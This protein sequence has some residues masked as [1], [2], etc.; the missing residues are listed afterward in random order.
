MIRDTCRAVKFDPHGDGSLGGG[1][2]DLVRS[3]FCLVPA[4]WSQ[5]AFGCDPECLL[6]NGS[7]HFEAHAILVLAHNQQSFPCCPH[8]TKRSPL[9]LVGWIGF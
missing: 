6:L 9:L 2:I 3:L 7:I 8:T 4:S 1:N 5:T